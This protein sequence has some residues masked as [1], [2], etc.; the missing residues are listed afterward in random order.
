MAIHPC[1]RSF[2]PQRMELPEELA[3]SVKFARGPKPTHN[4]V[5][6]NRMDEH[7]LCFALA[8]FPVIDQLCH[9]SDGSHLSHK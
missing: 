9:E 5:G 7:S 6:A 4:V 8:Q 2:P 3:I 1:L